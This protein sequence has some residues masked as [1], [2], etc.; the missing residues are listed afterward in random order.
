MESALSTS[1]TYASHDRPPQGTRCRA[2]AGD[3]P[4]T[5]IAMHLGSMLPHCTRIPVHKTLIRFNLGFDGEADGRGRRGMRR[6]TGGPDRPTGSPPP[7]GV[8]GGGGGG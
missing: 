1:S 8:G 4:A 2:S 7:R 3:R 5:Y 6:A